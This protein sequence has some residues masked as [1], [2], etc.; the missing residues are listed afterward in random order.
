ME[1]SIA[2]Y[3]D[4]LV[5]DSLRLTPNLLLTFLSSNSVQA[6]E[7]DINDVGPHPAVT[8]TVT[9]ITVILDPQTFLP[10]RI[11]AYEDH[12]IF[13]LSTNDF[14]V[15]NYTEVNGIQFPLNVR[16]LYN[17]KMLIE[18]LTDSITANPTFDANFFAGLPLSEVDTTILALQPSV[19]QQSEFYNSAEV[20]EY[21]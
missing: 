12:Q 15:Y 20:F 17:D 10:T 14:L 21:S 8:D 11:R 5:R 16:V 13:G 4:V 19:P 18:M 3:A 1:I 2:A 6:S 9:N 7:I